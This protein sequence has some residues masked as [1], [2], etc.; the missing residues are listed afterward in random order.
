MA[1]IKTPKSASNEGMGKCARCGI[2]EL[3]PD[4]HFGL[5]GFCYRNLPGQALN[6]WAKRW[7][8][9]HMFQSLSLFSARSDEGQA[10]TRLEPQR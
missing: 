6:V 3:G 1:K 4:Y 7:K 8:N 5:C 2:G 9:E 10:A